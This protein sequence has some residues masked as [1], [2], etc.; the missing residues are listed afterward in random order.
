MRRAVDVLVAGIA[1]AI[2]GPVIVLLAA[3]VRLT[4]R[5]PAIYRQERVGRSNE[6]FTI[7][8]LRSMVRGADRSGPLV[9]S[10]ADSRVT[11]LGAVLR[12]TK[13]DELPQLINVLKGDMT[14]IG[15]R[16][17]VPRYVPYYHDDE[18]ETLNVRPGLTGAG[19]VFYTYT[20]PQQATILDGED[21]EQQYVTRELH[22][23]LAIDLDYLRRRSLR[24]DLMILVRT[25]LL[26]A[27]LNS[28]VPA[29]VPSD[30]KL[31][32]PARHAP[33]LDD[34]DAP[35]IVM[36]PYAFPRPSDAP[37]IVMVP[38]A[39]P[40]GDDPP[41]LT[42]GRDRPPDDRRPADADLRRYR[43]PE[44]DDPPTLTFGRYRPR[45]PTTRR[46]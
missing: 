25:V 43:P 13:L 32:R 28:L 39:E 22:P 17:E 4:S 3:M 7:L 29:P 30:D 20:Q 6:P 27:K 44:T 31:A 42:F 38:R 15:P 34:D 18:R 33:A 16:P 14:L 8:K 35:T 46:R 24:Y 41:T 12:A 5:G 10:R 23:K 1:L 37:T 26:M 19:Q 9:T 36:S 11:R 2:T 21:P 40:D 45:R